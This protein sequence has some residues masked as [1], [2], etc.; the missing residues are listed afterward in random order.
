MGLIIIL[1]VGAVVGWLAG[2]ITRSGGGLLFD[3]LVGIA[4]A[5]IAGWLFGGGASIL[6][7]PI[8][9]MSFLYS[10]LGA[11]ILLIIV[12]LIRRAT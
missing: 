2:I 12:K 4:G 11:V 7:G 8:N 3:I 10:L 5:L 6:N 1:V 9:P